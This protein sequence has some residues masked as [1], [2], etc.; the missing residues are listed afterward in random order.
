MAG[1][2]RKGET[3]GGARG[4][5]HQSIHDIICFAADD[6]C[7]GRAQGNRAAAK[8]Q[9]TP[10]A[11]DPSRAG[12]GPPCMLRKQ[13]PS[14][15]PPPLVPPL[16]HLATPPMSPPLLSGLLHHHRCTGPRD[17]VGGR[18]EKEGGGTDRAVLPSPASMAD[19]VVWLH[20]RAVEAAL[21]KE[22]EGETSGRGMHADETHASHRQQI[23]G[24]CA[25]WMGRFSP[26]SGGIE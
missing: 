18:G 14:P 17:H 10:A 2:N 7:A 16:L 15:S 23:Q 9:G 3:A 5:P 13:G 6:V 4:E 26:V 8:W 1:R 25:A 11:V 22:R 19:A 24:E 12:R 20:A 21:R